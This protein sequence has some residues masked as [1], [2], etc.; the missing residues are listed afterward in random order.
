MSGQLREA[1]HLLQERLIFRQV[2][3]KTLPLCCDAPAV[4]GTRLESRVAVSCAAHATSKHEAVRG[5]LYEICGE[6]E[7]IGEVE[8][9][10][11]ATAAS[12]LNGDQMLGG[13]QQGGQIGSSGDTFRSLCRSS[14]GRYPSLERSSISVL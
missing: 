5:N 10:R 12:R 8:V 11:R 1:D 6:G 9:I 2:D 13:S 4:G 3:Y 7:S 14:G